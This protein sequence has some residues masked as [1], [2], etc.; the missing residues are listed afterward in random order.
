MSSPLLLSSLGGTF[1]YVLGWIKKE[2]GE[3]RRRG[4]SGNGDS[5]VK[6]ENVVLNINKKQFK[7]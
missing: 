3:R 6:S 2:D 5:Y 4:G 1:V 7:F